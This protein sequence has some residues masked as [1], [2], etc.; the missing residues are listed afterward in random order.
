M[1]LNQKAVSHAHSL[2]GS[3]KVDKTS[4]W[5]ISADDENAMLGPNSD[6]N[7]YGAWFLVKKPG[8]NPETKQAYGY[9]YGKG[10]KVYRSA[11][12]AIRQRA[13]Q[14]HETDVF[15]AAGRLLEEIDSVDKNQAKLGFI[16]EMP[17]GG[18]V[19]SEFQI[20]P[21]G[22]VHI[23]GSAPFTVDDA[24]MNGVIQQFRA[25]GLDMV[26]DYEHQTE[27]GQYS[28][29]DGKAPAAGW[30]K[31]LENRGRDGLWAKVDW[32]A[33]AAAYLANRE[34][35]YFSP[36]FIV[37]KEDGRRL[38][39]LLRVALTNAPRIDGIQPIVA[40]NQ[41]VQKE[42]I[43][44]KMAALLGLAETATEQEIMDAVKQAMG[45]GRM[46]AAKELGLAENATSEQVI[47]AINAL[48]GRAETVACKDVLDALGLTN[49][50][51]KSEIVASIHAL[52][53]RPGADV[54]QEIA[55]LK[56][57][58]AERDRDEL[59]ASALA[60]GKITPAQKDWA[61]EYALRDAEG[62]KL[63]IAKAP[64]VV[65][66]GSQIVL[67]GDKGHKGASDD[68]QVEINKMMGIDEETYKKYGPKEAA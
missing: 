13:G 34:Y 27:G 1:S 4:P 26:I 21:Y 31:S 2:I 50:A 40:K 55:S 61:D 62:F 43:M 60:A 56:A 45:Q 24:A 6:W 23:L 9:P 11:L 28:S 33:T 36:T 17:Q 7:A 65:P 57:R 20:F 16:A 35:R 15:D 54:L 52:K 25:R 10:G 67:P 66:T 38:I 68:A 46:M 53:Q 49:A 48:K 22:Q 14:Q 30:I 64:Q 29:P 5:S 42:G 59:V 44:K 39:S 58:A 51:S 3:G 41:D 32:T 63:F 19:P 8:E 18:P 47:A 37:S 12:E